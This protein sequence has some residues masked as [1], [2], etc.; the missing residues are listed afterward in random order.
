MG[1]SAL[2]KSAEETGAVIEKAVD[3]LR[4]GRLYALSL[5]WKNA[6]Y[7]DPYEADSTW[8]EILS[9]SETGT[10][11]LSILQKALN[12]DP[13]PELYLALFRIFA[14]HELFLDW[15]RS[16]LDTIEAL[17]ARELHD[18]KITLPYRFGRLLYD[19]FNDRYQGS[20]TDHLLA[21]E[22]RSLLEDSPKGVYQLNS[23]LTG[24][25]GVLHSREC[26]FIPPSLSLPLWHCS[27][28]GCRAPHSVE[29][30]PPDIPLVQIDHRVRDI[31]KDEF[32]PPS[33]W[34]H[35]LRV[36]LLQRR[37]RQKKPLPYYDLPVLIAEAII[38]G[39]RSALLTALL[40]T[41]EGKCLRAVLSSPPRKKSHGA[42]SAKDV[43]NRLSPEEQL[44][45]LLVLSDQTL[46]H[47]ID[48]IATTNHIA[49]SLGKIRMATQNPPSLSLS[50]RSQLSRFGLRSYGEHP[51]IT[52]VSVIDK[53]YAENDLQGDLEWRLHVSSSTPT[54]QGIVNYLQQN[55][56]AAAVKDLILTT[57][58]V[59]EHV[60]RELNLS[61]DTVA[62]DTGSS[63]DKILWKLGFDPP[64]FDDFIDRFATHMER[65]NEILLS[66]PAAPTEDHREQIRA[67]GVNLF[68]YVEKFLDFLISY[69]VWILASDH[70]LGT[71]LTFD[72]GQ[73]RGKV[74]EVLGD[75]LP[76]EESTVAWNVDGENS[77]GAL[78]R[79]LSEAVA[80]M[81][82]IEALDRDH[83]I[84]KE[85]DIPHHAN[86]SRARFPF[87]HLQ[88]WADADVGELRAY[89]DGYA[90]IVSLLQQAGLA[91]VRNGLDHMRDAARFPST[92]SMLAC[93]SRLREAHNLAAVKRYL[94]EVFWLDRV[95]Q[96]RFGVLDYHLRDR[97]DR[98]FVLHGPPMV[99][100][101]TD[102]HFERPYIIAPGNLLGG[103][104]TSIVFEIR[105]TTEYDRYWQ[106]YP[107]RRHISALGEETET[108]QTGAVLPCSN[109]GQGATK[110]R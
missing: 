86:A 69:N 1:K 21:G 78:L 3:S 20:R 80:W 99:L 67:A 35:S 56:P 100:C 33:E 24:P 29:L 88:L 40:E 54:T 38:G 41:E 104:N 27:D 36:R 14:H 4:L 6:V 37:E 105:E 73:A 47:A 16:D 58:A 49:L 109:A 97:N 72:L 42:G 39:E 103:P 43:V 102:V 26:R 79:Y 9:F 91:A 28:T 64:Q 15:I 60:C 17:F 95:E 84:R 10:S 8:P 77:L 90:S 106:D 57:H 32:G 87:Q 59:A 62:Q 68:V 13:S 81:Q 18:E 22:V 25:I 65:F 89:R 50:T 75:S 85:Q 44:Q 12:A 48:T 19:R 108:P 5:F 71:Q 74:Q 7:S 45:L 61:V 46:I 11:T 82:S 31:L 63:V 53:A 101:T 23:F 30:L 96:S 93:M 34:A 83:Y 52:L 70:F 2:W 66:A 94:P 76:Y 107:R 55:G 98:L 110:D 51:A 92:D